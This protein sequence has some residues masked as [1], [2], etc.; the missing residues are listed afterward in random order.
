MTIKKT[1]L[2][3][4][5]AVCMLISACGNGN[6]QKPLADNNNLPSL[7]AADTVMAVEDVSEPL[8]KIT[9]AKKIAKAMIKPIIVD[10]NPQQFINLDIFQLA[11]LLGT[12]ILVRRDGMVEVWQY[13]GDSC[14]LDIFL[15]QVNNIM[16]VQYV[17]LRGTKTHHQN[18]QCMAAILRQHIKYMS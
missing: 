11:K 9:N 8:I 17:D 4:I 3:I 16:K 2:I 6:G 1:H 5:I 10:D 12:P 7:N 14:I 13:K 15:Y 18:R